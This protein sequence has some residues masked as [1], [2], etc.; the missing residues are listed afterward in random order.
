MKRGNLIEYITGLLN[1]RFRGE[2]LL[3]FPG[4]GTLAA[5]KVL[6]LTSI[7]TATPNYEPRAKRQA[8]A[9]H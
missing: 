7:G 4:D 6:E 9:E 5:I 2:L 1:R 8:G 3:R